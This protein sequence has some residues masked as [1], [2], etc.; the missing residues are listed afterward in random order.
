MSIKA[1]AKQTGGNIWTNLPI[2]A[3]GL[4]FVG[5][6]FVAYKVGKNLLSKTRLDE[7]TRDDKQ[8]VDGWNNSF[9]TDSSSK[10]PTLS[11]T[12]MK[13]MA[14]KIE[15][16]LDGYGTRDAQL[17]ST[18]KKVKNNADFSG[19]NSAFGTRTIDAGWGIGWAS[20]APVKGAMTKCMQEADNA[21]LSTINKH[22]KKQGIKYEV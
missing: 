10:K 14:N 12:Q 16:C 17:I 7:T 15:D 21:T 5:G 22:L 13:Q 4:I 11:K 8:E 18:F 6:A 1:A 9:I 19:L 3:K 20:G 2:W